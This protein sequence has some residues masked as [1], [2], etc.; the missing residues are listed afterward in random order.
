MEGYEPL[1]R[2]ATRKI[3]VQIK[4]RG[5]LQMP[6][7]DMTPA[8]LRSLAAEIEA[9]PLEPE[10]CLSI[11]SIQAFGYTW[12]AKGSFWEHPVGDRTL[13][14]TFDPL[15]SRDDAHAMLPEGWREYIMELNPDGSIT[16]GVEKP[17]EKIES[18]GVVLC[19]QE[20]STAYFEQAARTA[21]ALRA[22]A[23]C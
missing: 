22:R 23:R 20:Q 5:R 8:D 1:P 12:N 14:N 15:R 4:K 11:R 9:A 16:F 19:M 10:Q 6:E 13:P 2:K 21:A 18:L 7:Y 17:V 3:A